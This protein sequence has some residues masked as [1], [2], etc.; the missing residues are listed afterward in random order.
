VLVPGATAIAAGDEEPRA[1]AT[2]TNNYALDH[3]A[4]S[5]NKPMDMGGL[6][7]ATG[8]GAQPMPPTGLSGT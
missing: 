6:T 5:H 1:T 7:F 2:A 3:N 4:A 8:D